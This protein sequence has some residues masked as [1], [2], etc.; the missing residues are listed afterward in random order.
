MKKAVWLLALALAMGLIAA[1]CGDDDGDDGDGNGGGGEA[2][3]KQEF[4]TQ[5]DQICSEEDAKLDAAAEDVFGGSNQPPSAAEQEQFAADTVIPNVRS[6]IDQIDELEPPEGDED[7]IQAI[8][9][10]AREDLDA[11][12]QDP[13]LFTDQGGEE[14][15]AEASRLAQQYGMKVCGE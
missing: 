1:G 12:E 5:A 6:Q 3:T 7:Q 15:L 10:S 13:S 14:P 2:L 4:I 8:V 11:G 9:D